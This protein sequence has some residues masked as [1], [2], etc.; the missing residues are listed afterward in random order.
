MKKFSKIVLGTAAVFGVLGCGFTVAGA[1]MG[2]SVEEM[3]YEGS[4]MQKAVNRMVRMVDHWDE[5]DDWDDD[6]DDDDWDEKQAVPSGDSGTYEFD[7]I[8]SMDIE[9]NYDEL[10]LRESEDRKITVT[11]D[12]DAADRV[13]VSTEGSELQIENKDDYRPE[14]R[15]VTITYPA[16]TEFTE[17]SIDIDKGTAALEDDLKAGEFSVS[18]GAGTLENYGIVTAGQTDIEVGVGTLELADLDADYIEAECGV[19]M[20]SL[21]VAGRKEDY[22]YRISCGVGSVLLG[23]DEFT[24]LGSTKKVDNNGASRKM[25]LECGMGTLEVDFEE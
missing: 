18:V 12:G 7:S 13:R 11:V 3:K 25:Q 19:G 16:G 22:N 8:S 21:D 24:G 15:T 14:E 5:D 6:W 10:I 9:L 20:M 2:A 23:E 1:A 4:N 17:V